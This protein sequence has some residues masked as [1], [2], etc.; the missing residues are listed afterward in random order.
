MRSVSGG[1]RNKG[2]HG[3]TSCHLGP[4]FHADT[5]MVNDQQANRIHQLSTWLSLVGR[6]L[7]Q[8]L[9]TTL[10]VVWSRFWPRSLNPSFLDN[11]EQSWAFLDQIRS[12]QRWTE[13]RSGGVGWQLSDVCANTCLLALLAGA[14]VCGAALLA[15]LV[16]C[17]SLLGC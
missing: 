10:T 1:M 11:E 14:L 8:T 9:K 3:S 15:A 4:L 2:P 5:Q 13:A 6:A 12:A 16:T 7:K 17:V